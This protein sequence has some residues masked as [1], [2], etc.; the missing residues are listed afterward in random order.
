VVGCRILAVALIAL[1]G[2]AAAPAPAPEGPQRLATEAAFRAA[3]VGRDLTEPETG[4]TLRIVP[5]GSWLERR[6]NHVA[7]SGVWRW[8]G[9]EWC[10][11]GRRDGRLFAPRCAEV[12]RDGADVVLGARR[13]RLR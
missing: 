10:H 1:A 12:V 11:E 5:D 3:I 9:G 13:L 7:A 2:C 8:L 4:A 6:A